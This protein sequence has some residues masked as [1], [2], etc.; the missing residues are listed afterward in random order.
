M[1]LGFLVGGFWGLG[2]GTFCFFKAGAF[3]INIEE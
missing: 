2:C 1:F 3:H